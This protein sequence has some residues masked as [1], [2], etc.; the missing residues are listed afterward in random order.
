MRGPHIFRLL[1]DMG[2]FGCLLSVIG[3][4]IFIL[5][6]S[7]AVRVLSRVEP[8]NRRMD[9]GQVWFNLVPFFNLLWLVVTVERVGESIRNE[10]TARGRHR[11]YE[12]YGKRVGLT[13]L[14]LWGIGLLLLAG[15]GWPPIIALIGLFAFIYWVAY[16]SQLGY[17]A[18]RLRDT[19][20][21]FAPPV[22][23]GW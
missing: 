15:E 20:P 3:F 17:Y 23:E 1:D 18:R 5:F 12:G 10:Y 19:D 2:G 13:W 21:T 11:K 22:D 4:A 9:P 6:L 7:A 14:A 8:E 16:W